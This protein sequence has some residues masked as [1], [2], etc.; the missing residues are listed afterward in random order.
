VELED[1]KHLPGSSWVALLRSLFN[2]KRK[3]E[4]RCPE[5]CLHWKSTWDLEYSERDHRLCLGVGIAKVGSRW[6]QTLNTIEVPL[7]LQWE[8]PF[9]SETIT[10]KKRDE[11]LANISKAFDS[12]EVPHRIVRD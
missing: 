2:K 6:Y 5:F 4:Y 1:T 11:I 12:F 9:S 10:V 7:K 8:S 3:L